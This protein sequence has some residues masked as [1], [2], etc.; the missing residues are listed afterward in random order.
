MTDGDAADEPS[1]RHTRRSYTT[2][3]AR[4]ITRYFARGRRHQAR[5]ECSHRVG[6]T[7]ILSRR[8]CVTMSERRDCP[9]YTKGCRF[10]RPR[11]L[12]TAVSNS[13]CHRHSGW[14]AGRPGGRRLDSLN[15]FISSHHRVVDRS[16]AVH[17]ACARARRYIIPCAER[18]TANDDRCRSTR[19]FPVADA[20][21]P[22][23]GRDLHIND[24]QRPR[25]RCLRP[26]TAAVGQLIRG[27]VYPR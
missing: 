11:P 17:T 3:S 2:R 10:R 1:R 12:Q 14:P 8:D 24:A 19:L 18:P 27:A 5:R 20:S 23:G 13:I 6:N 25:R 4:K 16:S 7:D 9:C 26:P 21:E 22:A 15:S